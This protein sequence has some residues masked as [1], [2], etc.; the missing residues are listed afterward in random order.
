MLATPFC[1]K[2][3][4]SGEVKAFNC[5]SLSSARK[6]REVAIVCRVKNLD[7]LWTLNFITVYRPQIATN[8]IDIL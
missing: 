4:T 1:K 5:V 8:K 7:F 2:N 6:S 3:R